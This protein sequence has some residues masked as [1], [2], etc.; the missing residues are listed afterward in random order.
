[1]GLD[2]IKLMYHAQTQLFVTPFSEDCLDSFHTKLDWTSMTASVGI[3]SSIRDSSKTC[4]GWGA[5][6]LNDNSQPAYL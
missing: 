5:G 6:L 2:D 4:G 3:Y 1:M